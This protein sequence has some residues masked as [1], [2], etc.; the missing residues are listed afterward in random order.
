MITNMPK[1]FV[2]GAGDAAIVCRAG[3]VGA[4]RGLYTAGAAGAG[5]AAGRGP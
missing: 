4:I 1:S 2:V 3:V 5:N